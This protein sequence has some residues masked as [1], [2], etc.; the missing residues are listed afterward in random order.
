MLDAATTA[1]HVTFAV[2]VDGNDDAVNDD[3]NDDDKTTSSIK[4]FN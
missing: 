4:S 3:D 1:T 2:A